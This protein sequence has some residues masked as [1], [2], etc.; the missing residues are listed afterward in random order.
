MQREL[1]LGEKE[2][3]NLNKKGYFPNDMGTFQDNQ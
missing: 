3:C 1:I 2:V